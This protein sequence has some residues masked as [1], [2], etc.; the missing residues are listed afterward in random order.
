MEKLKTVILLYLVIQSMVLTYILWF[1]EGDYEKVAFTV[2]EPYIFQ[3]AHDPEKAVSPARFSMPG[4]EENQYYFL[5]PGMEGYDSTWESI[6]SWLEQGVIEE[7]EEG[8]DIPPDGDLEMVLWFEPPFPVENW[9]ESLP[10]KEPKKMKKVELYVEED[11]VLFLVNLEDRQ[12]VIKESRSELVQEIKEELAEAKEHSLLYSLWEEEEM[13]A[14]LGERF[15]VAPGEY[16]LPAEEI[17]LTRPVLEWDRE[18]LS[19]E[20]LI[21]AFFLDTDMLRQIEVGE[22]EVIYTDGKEY[23]HFKANEFEYSAPPA[24]GGGVSFSYRQAVGKA[25]EYLC[26]YGGWPENLYLKAVSFQQ[27]SPF[28]EGT[29]YYQARWNYYHQGFPLAGK[30]IQMEYNDRGL[31]DYHRPLQVLQKEDGAVIKI[32]PVEEVLAQTGNILREAGESDEQGENQDNESRE[33]NVEGEEK[34]L[35]KLYLAYYVGDHEY[36]APEPA[37]VVRVDGEILVLQADSLN[38]LHRGEDKDEFFPGS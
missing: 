9:R 21:N 18:D 2:E 23:L 4:P 36:R 17:E 3:E 31:V 27:E 20:K 22:G 6:Y 26:H 14:Y 33:D 16:Y 13:G 7:V 11:E 8:T 35:E 5:K 38:I 25:T 1:D 34:T 10:G 28:I 32:A 19:S 30:E 29:G 24:K 15:T 12:S 37:W